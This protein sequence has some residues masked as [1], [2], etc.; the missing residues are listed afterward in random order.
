[1]KHIVGFSGGIDSQACARWVLNRYPKE[2]VV[3]LN[4]DAGGNEHPLTSEFI[5]WYS[6]HI[7]PVIVV[8]ATVAD[9]AG[10]AKGK[11]AELG[12]SP[13]DILT[14]DLMTILK[15]RWPSPKRQ[16]CTEH[17]K[18]R[19]ALRWME[20][21]FPAGDYCRY[22]G[23]RNDESRRRASRKAVEWDDFFD[24]D[25]FHP[26]IDWTKQMCF[27]YVKAHDGKINEL[28]TLG[29]NRVG[30][31]PC[32][33]SNKADILAWATRFP[34][35]IDKVRAWEKTTGRT[36]YAPMV[37]RKKINWI[38]EVVEWS[39]TTRGGKQYGLHVL[40]EPD[41]CESKFGLCE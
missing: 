16:F 37:P 4:S 5:D 34:E 8:Q 10:T 39:K 24:C 32:I 30:C 2:D 38:D 1:M 36:F 17:L 11:I 21:A 27:D 31:A 41:S 19:P 18:L 29:F 9:M 23:V 14:F 7:H 20:L 12:L 22:A 28:Y 33:N 26:I 40:H 13:D 6:C 35:M 25:L 3:L 15:G